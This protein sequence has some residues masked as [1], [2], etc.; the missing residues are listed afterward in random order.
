MPGQ[1]QIVG[2]RWQTRAGGA[3]PLRHYALTREIKAP[4]NDQRWRDG[5]GL[6]LYSAGCAARISTF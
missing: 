2:N 1:A 6:N 4:A 5:Q 3:G